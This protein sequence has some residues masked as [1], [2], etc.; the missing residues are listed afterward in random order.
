MIIVSCYNILPKK[1]MGDN[2][3]NDLNSFSG[4]EWGKTKLETLQLV[5]YSLLEKRTPCSI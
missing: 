5:F 2:E 4:G 3:S 1:N